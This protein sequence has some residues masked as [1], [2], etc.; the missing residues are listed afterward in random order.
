MNEIISSAWPVCTSEKVDLGT[1]LRM[2]VY[3]N[4]LPVINSNISIDDR[5]NAFDHDKYSQGTIAC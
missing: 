4:P 1:R 5:A 2:M 3:E